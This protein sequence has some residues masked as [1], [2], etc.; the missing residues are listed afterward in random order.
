MFETSEYNKST[1]HFWNNVFD[2]IP[3]WGAL[4][5]LTVGSLVLIRYGKHALASLL[6][7]MSVLLMGGLV[8][9]M[10]TPPIWINSML[11]RLFGFLDVGQAAISAV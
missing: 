3:I 8:A 11:W 6:A 5:V 9:G 4:L 1:R 7:A 10:I 2:G